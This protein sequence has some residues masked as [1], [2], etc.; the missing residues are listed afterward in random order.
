MPDQGTHPTD[1]LKGMQNLFEEELEAAE[2]MKDTYAVG[3]TERSFFL[4]RV[5]AFAEVVE[6][7]QDT[8]RR[9]VLEPVSCPTE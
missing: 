2:R 3:T 5:Q 1:F 6:Y 7:L 8:I 9:R 4:G